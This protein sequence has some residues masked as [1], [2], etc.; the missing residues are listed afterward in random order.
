MPGMGGCVLRV[1][2]RGITKLVRARAE[3]R[4]TD[5]LAMT[6]MAGEVSVLPPQ[7]QRIQ[8]QYP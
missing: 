4:R 8:V 7:H 3:D 6:E 5:D 1:I 2:G